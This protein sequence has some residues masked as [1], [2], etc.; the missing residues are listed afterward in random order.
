MKKTIA[1]MIAAGV[2]ASANAKD[3]DLKILVP[4]PAG[5][6]M[7]SIARTVTTG[8]ERL[9]YSTLVENKPGAGGITGTNEC[10]QRTATEKNLVCM[11]SQAQS[12]VV[13]PELEQF[14]KF[15]FEDLQFVKLLATSP[16]VLITSPKNTKSYDEIINDFKTNKKLNLGSASWLNTQHNK[17]FLKNLNNT[18]SEVIDYKGANQIVVDVVNGNLDYAFVAYSGAAG[19]FKGNALRIVAVCPPRYDIPDLKDLPTLTVKD[20]WTESNYA[21]FGL[22]TGP[23]AKKEDIAK[24]EK[25]LNEAYKDPTVLEGLRKLGL[26]RSD[27]TSDDYRKVQIDHRSRYTRLLKR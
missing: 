16:L 25:I 6:A 17:H 10:I 8:A 20:G 13:P 9:G 24:I 14:V 15:K 12:V 22:I 26:A 27:F 5:A 11:V 1:T 19:M 18:N 4:F 21:D 7:D 2:M 23:D 3:V